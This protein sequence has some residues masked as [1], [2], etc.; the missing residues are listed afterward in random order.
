VEAIDYAKGRKISPAT[1]ASV[2]AVSGQTYFPRRLEAK[3][4]A[5]FFPYQLNGER[6]NWKACAFPDKDFIGEK[7]GKLCF[8]GLDHVLSAAPGDVW[9][10]EGEW[11]YCSLIEAGVPLERVL[12]VP[13]GGR[14]PKEDDDQ[15]E[16]DELRGYAYVE[17]A[18]RLGLGKHKRFIWCGDNDAAGLKLRHD[19]ARLLGQARFWY[20][21]WPEGCKDAN[22]YLRSDGPEALH[23]LV[24]DGLLRWPIAGLYRLGELPEPAPIEVWRVPRMASWGGKI[25]L[26]PGTLSV[27]TG[28]PGHG[29]TAVWG[30]LWHDLS[31]EYGLRI[32]VAA[33]ETRAKPH[34]R[35]IFRRLR[36]RKLWESDMTDAELADADAWIDDRYTWIIHPEQKPTLSWLLDMAEAA[37]VRN[38]ANVV[39]IDPWNRLE[40]Q[41][42][43]GESETDYIGRCLTACYVFSQD[44]SVHVQILAHPAKMDGARRTRAPELEDIAGSKHFDNRVD[45]GFTIHRPGLFEDGKRNKAMMYHRKARFEELGHPCKLPIRYD[46][47]IGRF[48]EDDNKGPD[49]D[50]A[51]TA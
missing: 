36:T 28:H 38:G 10:V 25:A 16:G 39:Q 23:E 45:Q 12:S 32:A 27:C 44:M 37:V 48:I 11:D 13:N 15:D 31:E 47:R 42:E 29:K 1:L 21:D 3:S 22:D 2:G 30:Q 9:L 8:L 50:D 49:T 4:K 19:M 7:G 41:R 17:E 14:K 34:F 26:A 35:R 33:F 6:V 24:T 18:L 46:W 51:N 20:C 5:V 40:S 43:K